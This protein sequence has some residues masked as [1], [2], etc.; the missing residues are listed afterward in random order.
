MTS[1]DHYTSF[2]I[3]TNDILNIDEFNLL[4]NKLYYHDGCKN[5][6]CFFVYENISELFNLIDN[7]I[8]YILLYKKTNFNNY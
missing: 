5:N 7:L 4:N 1:D 6:G 8:P 2:F 3:K